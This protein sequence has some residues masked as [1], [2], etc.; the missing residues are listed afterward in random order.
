MKRDYNK[1]P[2]RIFIGVG[3][4]GPD[5][6]A[7]NPALGIR[8][9][10]CNLA[11][12]MQMQTDLRRH[13]VQ[14]KLSRYC[15]EPDTLKEEI[16]QCNAY[17]PDFAVEIHT[18]AGGGTGFEVYYQLEP[19]VNSKASMQ[20]AVLFDN[21]VCKYL[22]R[23][24]R[25]LKSSQ[26]LGWL[27][28][29]KAP[30]ILVENFF[31]DGPNAAWYSQPEQLTKLSKAYVR[32]ILEFYGIPYQSDSIMTLRYKVVNDDLNTARDCAASALLVNGSHYVNLRQLV[33]SFG[34]ATYYDEKIRKILIYP[35][36]YYSESEFMSGLLKISDFTTPLEREM[37][38]ISIDEADLWEFDEYDEDTP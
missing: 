14:V 17:D 16:A 15:D 34:M 12:A 18:N 3:H 19:W 7:V 4:G 2:L 13:G 6:G 32:S 28:Q 26:Q 33:K 35:P 30:C 27:K 29:V 9:A 11:I 37:A 20:M 23:N 25:G 31:V 5:A 8:E 36:E 21:N 1:N 24:T 10:S 38:G 22:G